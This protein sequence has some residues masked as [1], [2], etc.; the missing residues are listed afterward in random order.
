MAVGLPPWVWV[1]L[2]MGLGFAHDGGDR[3]LLH[4]VLIMLMVDWRYSLST[5][6]FF[7]FFFFFG[8]DGRL[9]VAAG[10]GVRCV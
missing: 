8:V 6:F 9:W 4:L 5:I 10:D 7:F 1:L 2:S 3:G